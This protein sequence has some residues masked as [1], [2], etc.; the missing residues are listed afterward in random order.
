MAV[1]VGR[2]HPRRCGT[3]AHGRALGR[4]PSMDAKEKGEQGPDDNQDGEDGRWHGLFVSKI[5]ANC[6]AGVLGRKYASFGTAGYSRRTRLV[7]N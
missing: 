2:R 1:L 4:E 3:Q 6:P 5:D 7:Q